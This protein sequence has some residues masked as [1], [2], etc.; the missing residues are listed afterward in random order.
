[1]SLPLQTVPASELL[2]KFRSMSGEAG[3]DESGHTRPLVCT[4]VSGDAVYVPHMWSHA[5]VNVR[6]SIGFA[7]EMRQFADF[8]AAHW[9][10]K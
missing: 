8:S 10:E 5:V 3:G 7:V 6:T 4:Q 1:M 2:G 9:R